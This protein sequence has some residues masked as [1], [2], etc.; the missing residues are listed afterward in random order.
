MKEYTYRITMDITGYGRNEKDAIVD[1]YNQLENLDA[2]EII[3][4]YATLK[5]VIEG[6]EDEREKD[7]YHA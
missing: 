7:E 3:R 2:G 4:E 6:V 5:T 1:L